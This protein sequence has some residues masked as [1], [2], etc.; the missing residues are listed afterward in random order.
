MRGRLL[1][2]ILC[3]LWL[4]WLGETP[5][6]TKGEPREAL[7]A[8]SMLQSGDYVLPVIAGWEYPFKP[9]LL[10]W[11]IAAFARIFN[12]GTVNEFISRLPSALAAVAMVMALYGWVK[13]QR[14]ERFAFLT[15]FITATSVEVFR[16][17][18]A[19]RLDMLLTSAMVC[20]L[21]CLYNA[22][23]SGCMRKTFLWYAAAAGLLTCAVLTKGPVGALLPCLAMGIFRLFRRDSFFRILWQLSLV[24]LVSFIIPA[25]WYYEAWLRGGDAFL[26]I[27]MEENFGRLLGKMSYESH[28]KPFWYNFLTIIVGLVPWTILVIYSIPAV[29]RSSVRDAFRKISVPSVFALICALTVIVFYCF[30]AS[31]RSVY[32]L[33]AYPFMAYGIAALFL[34]YEHTTSVRLFRWTVIACAVVAPVCAFILSVTGYFTIGGF[35]AYSFLIICLILGVTAAFSSRLRKMYNTQNVLIFIILTCVS[36]V[37]MPSLY[38][39]PLKTDDAKNLFE[40]IEKNRPRVYTIGTEQL[41]GQVYWFNYYLSNTLRR[42]PEINCLSESPAGTVVILPVTDEIDPIRESGLWDIRQLPFNP[43]TRAPVFFLIHR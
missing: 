40:D 41:E 38:R 42:I 17:A 8:V 11:I 18:T 24:V 21:L 6:F 37:V 13:R 1:F 30:P 2:L 15:A 27:M 23:E 14:G 31:K 36:V 43:D 25:V 35:L 26:N 4:P 7:V 33:P 34:R 9:P 16:A 3:L 22:Y 29:L 10:A 5:F 39:N 12:G 20:G 19:C 32:L 28:V